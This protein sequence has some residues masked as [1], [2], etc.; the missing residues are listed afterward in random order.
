M[1]EEKGHVHMVRGRMRVEK[2]HVH[3]VV[4]GG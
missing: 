3:M 1:R 2:G 4:E